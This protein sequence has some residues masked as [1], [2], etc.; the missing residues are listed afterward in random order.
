[1]NQEELKYTKD[2]LWVHAEGD[3][4]TVGL[5]D[6]AQNELGDIVFVELPEVGNS[7]KKG[8]TL[9][10]VESVKSVS[11]IISPISGEIKDSNKILE[12]AP[13][14]INSDPYGKGWVVKMSMS[15]ED[16]L[17]ELLDHKAYIE[18]TESEV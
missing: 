15:N 1:M 8:E 16:E 14:T 6:Y 2:H 11:D 4:A 3:V 10:T 12:D 13:D 9:G 7:F 18:F 5:S 17:G